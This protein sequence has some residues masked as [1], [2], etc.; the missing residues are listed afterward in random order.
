M[1]EQKRD[2]IRASLSRILKMSREIENQQF[3]FPKLEQH[4]V[5]RLLQSIEER[6]QAHRLRYRN[7]GRMTDHDLEVEQRLLR[8]YQELQKQD[9]RVK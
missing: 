4:R 9:W 7:I 3:K 8:Q 1:D 2:Q 6:L 5:E